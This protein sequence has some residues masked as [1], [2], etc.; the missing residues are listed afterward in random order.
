CTLPSS[1][2]SRSRSVSFAMAVLQTQ[3]A[4]ARPCSVSPGPDY[5]SYPSRVAARL[6]R[7]IERRHH[8]VKK[9]RS[10]RV[11][12]LDRRTSDREARQ[13]ALFDLLPQVGGEHLY[14]EEPRA[15][16]DRLSA[17]IEVDRRDI[18]FDD[19]HLAVHKLLVHEPHVL[20]LLHEPVRRV[21]DL[22]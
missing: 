1:S 12:L 16:A 3:K 8:T 21:P 7:S 22:N 9:R 11:G 4:P 15:L 19:L 5:F 14:S 10:C 2:S 18:R 17:E 20:S 6:P 13:L